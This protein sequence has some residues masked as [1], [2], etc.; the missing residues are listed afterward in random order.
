MS[1]TGYLGTWTRGNARNTSHVWITK[2]GDEYRLRWGVG[3]VDGVWR[4]DCSWEGFCEEWV[5][6]EK[7]AEHR[8]K[9]W[10]DEESEKLRLR[11]DSKQLIPT[12]E[13]A[14]Y[15][16]ELEPTPDGM[17]LWSYTVEQSGQFYEGEARPKRLL[18]KISDRVPDPPSG[19]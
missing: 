2:V 13:E 19:S 16:H 3:S 14:Y 9:T 17:G 6:Q 18:E 5:N 8:C 12:I 15:I 1:N 7:I 10:V 4:I 11:C